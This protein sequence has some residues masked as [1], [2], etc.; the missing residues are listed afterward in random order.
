MQLAS[1]PVR[2]HRLLLAAASDSPERSM[3][4]HVFSSLANDD[5]QRSALK[6]ATEVLHFNNPSADSQIAANDAC[7]SGNFSTPPP[8]AEKASACRDQT[9][10]SCSD[11]R[12]RHRHVAEVLIGRT[13]TASRLTSH[14]VRR[15]R[16]EGKV[17]RRSR[18]DID[19]RDEIGEAAGHYRSIIC[20]ARPVLSS[21]DCYLRCC[22][23]ILNA[24]S[25]TVYGHRLVR[26]D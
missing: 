11:N 7:R 16:V 2:G 5:Q 18:V 3:R 21:P 22:G 10:Q 9:R 24:E 19:V 17:A 12:A 8:I 20:E 14:T 1:A 25:V 23:F 26:L 6:S 13:G 15:I 4:F